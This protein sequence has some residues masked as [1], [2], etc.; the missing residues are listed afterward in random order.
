MSPAVMVIV[1][2]SFALI[3]LP[4]KNFCWAIAMRYERE[5]EIQEN[6]LETNKMKS[7]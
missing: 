3:D 4:R 1:R 7:S 5:G 2:W 6:D